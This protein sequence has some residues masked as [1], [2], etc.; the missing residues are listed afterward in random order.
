MGNHCIIAQ[1]GI[2]TIMYRGS[3]ERNNMVESRGLKTEGGWEEQ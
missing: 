1:G 3:Q 2:Y